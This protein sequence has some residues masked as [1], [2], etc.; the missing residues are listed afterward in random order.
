MI[1]R[2]KSLVTM[3]GI[4]FSGN[5][6]RFD[7]FENI[8]IGFEVKYLPFRERTDLRNPMLKLLFTTHGMVA[9]PGQL[10]IAKL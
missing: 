10:N 4:I 8:A 7:S 1:S 3:H 6:H 2:E 9:L 5:Q